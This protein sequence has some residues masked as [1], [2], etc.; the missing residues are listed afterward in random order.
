MGPLARLIGWRV[1]VALGTLLFV[2]VAVFVATTMLPGDVA[3]AVLG[4]SATPEAVAGLRAAMHLDEPAPVRYLLWLR[5]LLSGNPG[6]SLASNLP[7]AEMI[8]SRLPKSLI[9]A[10]LATALCIPIGLGLGIASAALRGS[11]FDRATSV[12]TLSIISVPEF[13]IA[14]VA[15][16]IFAVQLRWF[17][18]LSFSPRIDSVWAFVRIY[19]LPVVSLSFIVIAQMMR[20]TRA[21]LIDALRQPYCEMARLKGASRARV[22]LRHAVPN[23]IGPMA[24]AVALSL[25]HLL[26]GA[27][28]IE[29][30]FNYPGLA[31]LLVDAVATRDMPLVQSCAMI[32]CAAY[33]ALVATV[34]AVAI[35]GTLG[36]VAAVVGGWFD[37]V[38]SRFLDALIS[39]PSLLFG[40]V[41]IAAL[42]ASIPVLIGTAALIYTPGAYRIWRS[43]ALNVSATDF[44]AVARARGESRVYIVRAEILPNIVGPV[45]TDLGLRFVFVVLLLSS[46]SFLG[47]GIQPPFA[48]WGS[49]VKENITGLSYG[50]PAAIMPAVALATLTV[51]VNLLVDNMPGARR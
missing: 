33:L 30:V 27:I 7:V 23:A 5:D 29:T 47:L 1:L 6:K 21:A 18:A 40:L 48:D 25:S 3:E 43:L 32:F 35:G 24:N 42:G 45:L 39:I 49:L 4:Q 50:A 2:S 8:A 44:V 28:V 38:L 26:G 10:A 46:L 14:T 31:R 20:L 13:F 15:V 37:A 34:L 12:A 16:L 36:M 11:A 9:L 51:G 41:A 17:P 19:T 22:V